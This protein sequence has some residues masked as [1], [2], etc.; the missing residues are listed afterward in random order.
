[1]LSLILAA[2]A[3]T[4][5]AAAQSLHVYNKCPF[6]VQLFTQTSYGSI[7]NNFNVASGAT[8]AMGISPNWA[9]AINVGEYTKR[10]SINTDYRL[11]TTRHGLQWK[12][13]RYGWSVVGRPH[14]VLACRVQLLGHPWLCHLRHLDGNS[15][16]FYLHSTIGY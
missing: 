15:I 4:S 10:V 3:V 6:P 14:A 13:L 5:S 9:G 16:L 1:M 12:Q 2:L 8:Q 7:G 11:N